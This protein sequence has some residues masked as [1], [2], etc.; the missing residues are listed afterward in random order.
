MRWLLRF[1]HFRPGDQI[2]QASPF[3]SKNEANI[4]D[5][6]NASKNRY[7]ADHPRHNRPQQAGVD[8]ARAG[9]ICIANNLHANDLLPNRLPT[10]RQQINLDNC[11][12]ESRQ[13]DQQA[14]DYLGDVVVI[15]ANENNYHSR[16][17]AYT[18]DQT[19]DQD[20]AEAA[21]TIRQV[22]IDDHNSGHK[23]RDGRSRGARC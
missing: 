23:L 3:F 8:K 22:R 13:A 2:M 20:R 15:T 18:S 14:A 21:A 6:K 7:A 4:D 12:G 17:H 1:Q 16:R 5:R 11:Q 19:V 9:V 10:R